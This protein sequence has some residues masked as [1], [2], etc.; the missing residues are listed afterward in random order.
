MTNT[1]AI[2]AIN[3]T[4]LGL[5]ARMVFGNTI[6]VHQRRRPFFIAIIL[7]ILIVVAEIG[8]IVAGNGDASWR[9]LNVVSNVLGFMLTPFIP[10]VLLSIFDRKIIQT[11]WYL[12]IPAF[13]NGV[14]AALSPFYGLLF[15]ID[16]DN[17]YSRGY[18]F[19]FFV[20]VYLIHLLFMVLASFYNGRRMLS[21]IHWSIFGLAIY[22]V[23]GTCIQLVFPAV[24]T[25]W[26][27]VTLSLF[28]YYLLLTEYDGRFDL[29]TGLYNRAAFEKDAKNIKRKGQHTIIVMDLNDFKK[30]NDTYGHEVGDA[31]LKKVAEIIRESFD[32]DCSSYR[33][34]GDEFYVLCRNSHPD[35]VQE[36]LQRMTSRLDSEREH[37]GSVPRIAYGFCVS[38]DGTMDMTAMLKDADEAMYRFKLS[39]KEAQTP[40][41]MVWEYSG[42]PL[43][44][45][46]IEATLF[47][48]AI[49]QRYP[50]TLSAC[51][52][53]VHVESL[54]K[55]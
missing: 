7:T 30:I 28:L 15:S 36:R 14:A 1:I 45:R 48:N 17:R 44:F 42:C 33:I 4:A 5:L 40:Q 35:L 49:L 31:A 19:P 18:L 2:A 16:A 52:D 50:P 3:I 41:P 27:S 26:H 20:G 6:L 13:L 11:R 10:L 39:Q 38:S 12:L 54:I 55:S 34:G 9:Y 21:S 37:D 24:Y 46:V 22:V 25:S 23:A 51:S 43:M 8:S 32:D 29:L 53:C 47:G